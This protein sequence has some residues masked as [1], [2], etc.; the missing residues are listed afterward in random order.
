MS[1]QFRRMQ[2]CDLDEVMQ[3]EDRSY[4]VPWTKGIFK[5]CLRVNYPSWVLV[6]D[7]NIIGYI[8]FSVGADEAHLLNICISPE[9]RREGLGK[10]LLLEMTDLFK[11]KDYHSIFLEVR[12]SSLGAMALYK[13][14]GFEK[15]GVRKDYYRT[16]DGKEDAVT[17][18]LE[19]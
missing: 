6:E 12:E 2:E 5:D 4:P 17:Y 14:L 7:I 3:I 1:I 16:L 13:S 9:R 10:F 19:L 11:Q 18:K 15:L 8:L